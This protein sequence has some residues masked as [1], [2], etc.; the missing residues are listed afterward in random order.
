M[1]TAYKIRFYFFNNAAYPAILKFHSNKTRVYR[2]NILKFRE[3]VVYYFTL[4][5]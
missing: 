2:E 1:N 5:T 4:G 3:T